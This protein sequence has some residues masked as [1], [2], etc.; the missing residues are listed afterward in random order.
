M[1]AT[2]KYG[3]AYPHAASI[4]ADRSAHCGKASS[5]THGLKLPHERDES[6]DEGG[7]AVVSERVRQAGRD[8]RRGLRDTDRG[9]EMDRTYQKQKI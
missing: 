3:S 8:I 6:V 9:A 2:I 5:S 4:K 1:K 7:G